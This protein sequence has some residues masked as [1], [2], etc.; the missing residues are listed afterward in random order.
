MTRE[1]KTVAVKSLK[2]SFDKEGHSGT[3]RST[4]HDQKSLI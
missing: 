2:R 3:G 1:L 4:L